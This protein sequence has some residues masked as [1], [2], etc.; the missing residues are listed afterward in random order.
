MIYSNLKKGPLAR[1]DNDPRVDVFSAN[2]ARWKRMRTIMNPTF[3]SSKL[4][5][6]RKVFLFKLKLNFFSVD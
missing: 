5:D 3:S 4:R 2:R 1:R 6:V